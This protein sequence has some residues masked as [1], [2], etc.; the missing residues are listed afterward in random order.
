MIEKIELQWLFCFQAVYEKLSF[1]LAAQQLQL[2]VSNVSRHVALLEQQLNVR[3]L[4]RTTRKMI[5]TPAGKQLYQSITPLTQAMDHSLDELSQTAD[6]LSGHLKIMT[7]DLPFMADILADFCIRHPQ[8][9]LS[10]D[11]QLDPTEGLLEGFDL[12]LRFGRGSLQDSS[13]VAREILRWS[14][15]VVAAPKLL[16]RH[17]S[18]QSL[19]ELKKAPCITSMSVLKGMPWRFKHDQTVHVSSSYKVNSGHMAKAAALK[20]LG[21]AIMPLHA[22]QSEIDNGSLIKIDCHREPEDLVLYAFY[23]GRKYPQV[24]TKAFLEHLQ[25]AITNLHDH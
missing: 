11:T 17:P 13:W 10:C 9:K 7:P 5:P 15:C 2:P 23:S 24:K 21:F 3:L 18:P 25:S 16:E 20:G 8:L 19:D 12:V 4:E 22:C 14:S 6:T 1:K